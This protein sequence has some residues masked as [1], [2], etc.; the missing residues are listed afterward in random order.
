MVGDVPLNIPLYLGNPIV[1]IGRR[2][3]KSWAVVFMPEAPIYKD[4]GLVFR[5]DDIWLARQGLNIFSVP[6]SMRKQDLPDSFFWLRISASDVRHIHASHFF[7][8]RICHISPRLHH[9]KQHLA[10]A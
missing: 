10:E 4:N 5:K 9:S 1:S 8:M 2:P 7:G 6:E 3:N